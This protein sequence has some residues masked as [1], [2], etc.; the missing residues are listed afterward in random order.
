M[1]KFKLLREGTSNHMEGTLSLSLVPY[2]GS[3]LRYS[4]AGYSVYWEVVSITYIGEF[5]PDN[6][7]EIVASMEPEEPAVDG[8]LV[9]REMR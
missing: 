5:I 6:K 9:V 4:V 7:A 1:P 3:R 8:V 2:P